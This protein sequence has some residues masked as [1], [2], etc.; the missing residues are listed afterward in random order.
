MMRSAVVASTLF[1]AFP[2]AGLGAAQQVYPTKPIR[3]IIP[4]VPGGPSDFLSRLVGTKLSENL[5]QQIVPDNRGSAGG[6]VGFEM[7]AHSTPD[8]YTML[9][10]AYSGYTINPHVYKKLPY[11]PLKELQ[12]ITQLTLGGNIFVINPTIKAG[13][14]QEFIALAK[15][16]PGKL[17]FATTGAGPLLATERFKKEAGINLVNI[18]YKGTGQAQMALLSNEVQFFVENPLIA[19]PNIRNGK[20]RA[21]AVTSLK[22]NPVLPDL[23]TV[24]E[25]G[26]PGYENVTWHSFA[27]PAGVPKPILRK[28]HDEIVKALQTPSV[29]DT[30]LAQ[31]LEPIGNT[32]EQVSARIRKESAE[33]GKLV[34][35]IGYQPQ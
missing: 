18:P 32:P 23:P 15:T 16:M 34:K 29:R 1:L 35:A 24:A 31:G 11:D 14:L 33:Y 7:G 3:L 26:F 17:N 21:L 20:V 28:M 19:V 10:A 22:R 25:Q 8:G 6:I 4:F 13:T 27:F 30:I 5:G 2:A 9:M 12:P